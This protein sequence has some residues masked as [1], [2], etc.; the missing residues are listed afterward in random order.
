[1]VKVLSQAGVSL[2]D[3]YNVKGSIAG[4]EE[5]LAREVSLFHEMG[6]TIFS[7]RFQT[8]ISRMT[9]GDLTQSTD[10]NLISNNLPTALN[11]LLGLAI[12][13]DDAARITR[14]SVSVRDSTIALDFPVWVWD[15]TNLQALNI[16]SAPGGGVNIEAVLMGEGVLSMLPSFA[17]GVT[18]ERLVDQLVLRGR[19]A[20][21]GA[22]TV[23]LT[24]LYYIGFA[25]RQGERSPGLPIPSW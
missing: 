18:G 8:G 1:M 4:V 23:F 15:G 22:G 2:A 13:T 3:T 17:N 24:A 16:E 6:G 21:F 19:T 9:T 10:F 14:A 5:L 7:E 20:A 25:F 11:R 12:I